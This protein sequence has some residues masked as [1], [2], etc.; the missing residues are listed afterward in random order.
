[1]LKLLLGNDA[2]WRHSVLVK[3]FSSFSTKHWTLS[4]LVCVRQTVRLTTEFVDWCRTVYI[5][6]THVR[7]TSRCDQRLEAA[8]YWNKGKHITKRHRQNSW[9]ME[10]AVACKHEG[11][12]TSLW[13]SRNWNR[14]FSEPTQYTTGSFQSHAPTVYRGK[15]VVM[16][17][18]HHSYLKANKV[19]NRF[20]ETLSLAFW[21][22]TL[23]NLI[24]VTKPHN[25][26]IN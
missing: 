20:Q 12:M 1:M 25:F 2:F 21:H 14:L 3:Q 7:D 18:F 26:F 15:H 19:S 16:R 24:F 11:K 8:P 22:R 5:V 9:S 13:T 10:K 17:H 4:L 6:Q 23:L